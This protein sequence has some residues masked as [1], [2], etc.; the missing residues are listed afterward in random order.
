MLIL[1]KHGTHQSHFDTKILYRFLSKGWRTSVPCFDT[2]NQVSIQLQY[3]INRVSIPFSMH[4]VRVLKWFNNGRLAWILKLNV[5]MSLKFVLWYRSAS[6]LGHFYC[7]FSN[8]S[9][10]DLLFVVIFFTKF[11]HLGFDLLLDDIA[12][13]DLATWIMRY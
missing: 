5:E 11:K 1:I 3:R 9:W 7:L 13:W 8:S 2:R 10:W 12:S 6:I 4:S